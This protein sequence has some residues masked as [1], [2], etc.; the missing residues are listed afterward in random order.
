M[1]K[2]YEVDS[3]PDVECLKNPV[4]SM[5]EPMNARSTAGWKLEYVL[6][7]PELNYIL[8]IWSTGA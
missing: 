2:T 4:T 7:Y 5:Q 8:C 6:P 3:I 1:A